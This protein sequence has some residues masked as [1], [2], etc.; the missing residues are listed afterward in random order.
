MSILKTRGVISCPTFQ[1]LAGTFLACSGRALLAGAPREAGAERAGLCLV[2]EAG[3][4]WT[5]TRLRSR[6]RFGH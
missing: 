4:G 6:H 2:P 1:T 5:G 3:M